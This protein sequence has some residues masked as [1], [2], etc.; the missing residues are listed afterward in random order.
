MAEN[1]EKKWPAKKVI[2]VF[3]A[4]SDDQIFGAGGT[5]AK[6]AKEGKEIYTYIFSFG[7]MS[8]PWLKKHATVKMRVKE[9][10]NADNLI[11]GKGVRFFDLKE[12]KFPET[13]KKIGI[14]KE[15]EKV[16]M[17][18]K[19]AKIFTHS[20]DDP[21]PDH[22]TV[23]SMVL[24]VFDKVKCKCDVYSFDIWNIVMTKNRT[25]PK[26][27]IDISDTF[28]VKIKALGLF[29][30][31]WAAK[32]SLLWSVYARAILNGIKARVKFAEVFRKIR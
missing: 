6:Y 25:A 20:A 12:G 26:L 16:I 5:L 2:V 11:G 8:H 4:H 15:I 24:E 21:H 22:K 14:K 31:Q 17:E 29:K 19:P 1:H 10:V 27:I 9:S 28:R 32:F 13:G 23:N 18:K 30:S 7:E 3:C